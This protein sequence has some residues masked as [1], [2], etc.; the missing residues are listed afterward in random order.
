MGSERSSESNI[1]SVGENVLR[2][3]LAEIGECCGGAGETLHVFGREMLEVG[4]TT[5]CLGRG[6]VWMLW[7]TVSETDVWEGG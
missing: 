5:V 7:V 3:E 1:W 2:G 6:I 4:V